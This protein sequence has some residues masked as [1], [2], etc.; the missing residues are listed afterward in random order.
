MCADANYATEHRSNQDQSCKP[1]PHGLFK[2]IWT[3]FRECQA[4]LGRGAPWIVTGSCGAQQIF[5]SRWRSRC[6][7]VSVA[8]HDLV[9]FN[10]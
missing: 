8:N 6:I 1:F 3:A 9:S 5:T 4:T 2:T 7:S 10:T